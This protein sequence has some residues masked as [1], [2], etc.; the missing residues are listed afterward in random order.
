METVFK[1][2]QM[3]NE[4]INQTKQNGNLSVQFDKRVDIKTQGGRLLASLGKELQRKWSL[5]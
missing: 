5:L 3:R 2:S 1:F 4:I